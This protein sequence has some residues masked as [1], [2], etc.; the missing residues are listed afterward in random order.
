[1]HYSQTQRPG[2]TCVPPWFNFS[3]ELLTTH[4]PQH[5]AQFGTGN[6]HHQ[7]LNCACDTQLQLIKILTGEVLLLK[8]WINEPCYSRMRII[9]MNVSQSYQGL[10][11][12]DWKNYTRLLH[13]TICM[14]IHWSIYKNIYVKLEYSSIP[15]LKKLQYTN[16]NGFNTIF[17]LFQATK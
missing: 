2:Q 11:Y 7:W 10:Y 1:M 5:M 16:P 3:L 14:N 12:P 6:N 17:D 8:L 13:A 9:I 15:F 4:A